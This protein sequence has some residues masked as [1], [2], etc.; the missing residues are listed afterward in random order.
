[1]GG[2]LAVFREHSIDDVVGLD[3]D[4]VD[5]SLLL[6]PAHCFI[7]TDLSR[8]IVLDREFDVAIC[9]E[10]AEHLPPQSAELLIRSLSKLSRRVVFSAA[11]PGQG[12]TH[13]V[14]EQWPTYWMECFHRQG[15]QLVDCFRKRIWD[16]RNIA[17]CYRQNMF[18]FVKQSDQPA[19]SALKDCGEDSVGLPLCVVHPEVFHHALSRQPTL[20]PLIR[21]L[22]AALSMALRKRRDTLLAR[23]PFLRNLFRAKPERNN[24]L[25]RAT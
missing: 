19:I 20:R 14:N 12:G 6:I 4:Y 5:K 2:W 23:T 21:A 24:C 16:N 7:E 3:G 13:H 8:G 10:V 15:Y 9:L 11:I 17:C 25:S 1:V 18:L 22:P